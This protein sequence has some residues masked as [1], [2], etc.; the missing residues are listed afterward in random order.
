[1]CYEFSHWFT[2]ARTAEPARKQT[3][4]TER[5][6]QPSAPAQQPEPVAAATP[7]KEREAAPA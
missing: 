5:S 7:V 3:P 4:Q 1:M 2:K 6:T